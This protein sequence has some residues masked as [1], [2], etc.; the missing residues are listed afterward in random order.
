MWHFSR[1]FQFAVKYR[2]NRSSE[3]QI[4][5]LHPGMRF[6][7]VIPFA[8]QSTKVINRHK[9]ANAFLHKG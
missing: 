4:F 3:A 8:I 2:V 5:L 9:M 6:E 7:L 1:G